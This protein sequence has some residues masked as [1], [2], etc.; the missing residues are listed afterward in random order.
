MPF[1]KD[2][3]QRL[4]LSSK[5]E[6]KSDSKPASSTA[7]QESTTST[8]KTNNMSGSIV[9][10]LGSGPRVGAAVAEAFAASGYKVAIASRK[11]TDS[12]TAEGYIS[13]KADFAQPDSIPGVF[14]TV[15]KQLGAAPNIVIYNAASLTPPPEGALLAIPAGR[16]TNDLNVNVVSPFIAAE[17]AVEGWET[18]SGGSKLFIYTGNV[19]NDMVLPVPMMLNLGVGKAASAYWIGQADGAYSSKGYR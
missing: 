11:G 1:L 14:D 15:K 19:Q 10:V 9:L 16:I 7:T 5:P 12:K 4:H 13:I 3:S 17:Q 18:L 6:S 8:P 2:L